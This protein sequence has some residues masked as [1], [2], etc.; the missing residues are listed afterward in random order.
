[1]VEVRDTKGMR[2]V[3]QH[4]P[5]IYGAEYGQMMHDAKPEDQPMPRRETRIY[6]SAQSTYSCNQSNELYQ[7]PS[8]R[9]VVPSD[10][11]QR[12]AIADHPALNPI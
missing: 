1:M 12:P 11:Q 9:S 2:W 6:H 7:T 10:A 3:T 5:G 8:D 4:L